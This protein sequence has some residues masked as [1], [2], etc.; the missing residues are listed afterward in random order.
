MS[1][2]GAKL[3]VLATRKELLIMGSELHRVQL[4]KELDEL[5]SA[6]QGMVRQGERAVGVISG[7]AAAFSSV[8]ERLTG[9]GSWLGRLVRGIRMGASLWN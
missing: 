3:T 1:G 8:R 5:V 2:P 7:L 6:S 4:L 9:T